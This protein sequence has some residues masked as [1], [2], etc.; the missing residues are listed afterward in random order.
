MTFS[1]NITEMGCLKKLGKAIAE[2]SDYTHIS[3]Y[4]LLAPKTVHHTF[5]VLVFSKRMCY[6]VGCFY[7]VS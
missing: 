4:M 6:I 2:A 3:V 1:L 5:F 7:L